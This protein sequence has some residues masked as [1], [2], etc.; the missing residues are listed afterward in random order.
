MN[1]KRKPTAKGFSIGDFG[2]IWIATV[3]LFVVSYFVAPGTVRPT[4]LA[5][6]L[7]FAAITALVAVGQTVVIQQRGLDMSIV[8]V[9]ALSG[10]I[11]AQIGAQSGNITFGVIAAIAV[12]AML[13]T[14]N[15]I[16]VSRL[17]ITPIVATL[18]SN[19]I[20][21]GIVQMVSG[22][23]V[24]MVPYRLQTLIGSNV[25]GV[26]ITVL[27]AVAFILLV[28]LIIRKT[29]IGRHF[30]IVGAAPRNARA[31]GIEVMRYQIGTYTFASVC[32]AVAG[33]LLSGVIGT[34]SHL[35]GPEYLLPGIAAV[36]V[37]GTPFTGGK[38][39]VV[40]SGIAALFMQQLSQLVLAMGAGTAMQ[41]LV[42]ALAIV[43]A[44]TI[45]HL[46]DLLSRRPATAVRQV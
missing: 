44:V 40:A 46:P 26:P 43:I 34:A 5:A 27:V 24:S 13:G 37:G 16:L 36:V 17:S 1:A 18:A 31:A 25:V 32:F 21:L 15:G 22:N 7:P 14:V 3:I 29:M 30:I 11:C 8:G 9:F 12:A 28:T 38:G 45:R 10:L 19:A 33:I 4:A 23:M 42:Q 6:M 20:F 41:L 2:W 39:S 35:A